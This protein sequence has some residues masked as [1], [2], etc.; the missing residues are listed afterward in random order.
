M[1]NAL[2]EDGMKKKASLNQSKRDILKAAAS[3]PLAASLAA[4]SG[5]SSST[6]SSSPNAQ[7]N[8]L[9]VLV[10]QMRFPN[11]FPSGISNADE[12]LK[13]F[14]P[15]TYALWKSGVKFSNHY[16]A[17]TACGPS[18]ATLVT[19][20]YTQQTW[21]V[22]TYAP[23]LGNTPPE[24]SPDMPTYGKL[25]QA[26]GYDTP[27]MGKWHL[28]EP[29]KTGMSRYGF[30]G[31]T[32]KYI[33]DAANLQG[34]YSD[35]NFVDSNGVKTPYYN[36]EFI[37]DVAVSWLKAKKISDR[38]W[39]LTVGLQNPH[40]YQFFPSGT[41]FKT[42]TSLYS[43][44]VANPTRSIQSS[45]YSAQPSATGVDWSTNVFNNIDVQSYG[46]PV[47][48]P[49]WESLDS[50]YQNKPK[51]QTLCRQWNAMQFGSAGETAS[52]TNYD[53]KV[54]P[55]TARY[56]YS[57][58]SPVIPGAPVPLTLG[59]SV[60]P[61]GYWQR[62]MAVY[63]L[64]MEIVDKSIG[65]VLSAM[66]A[67]VA[68][69][70]VIVFTSDHGEQAGSH[71]FISNKSSN[72]YDETIRVPLIVSDPTGKFTGD[73]DTQRTQITSAVDLAPMM[74]SFAYGGTRSWLT[75]DNATLYS[76]RF[77][78]FPLLKSAAA[79]GRDYALF[80]TD[81]TVSLW[82][83]FVT[84]PNS[85]K[86]QT[87]AHILGLIKQNDK[88]GLCSNWTPGTVNIVNDGRQ[89]GEYY[90]RSTPTG[91]LE[92]DNQ[93]STPGSAV[94]VAAMKNQLLNDL[95]PN[96]MRAALPASLKTPQDQS[97]QQIID[98]YLSQQS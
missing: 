48:P 20:L 30:E 9:F 72:V 94:K 81:E 80:S 45:T 47:L 35:P 66:P 25:F 32:E 58:Y 68:K 96:E 83:D 43:S 5:G 70:T 82:Q 21:N 67:D 52:V 1:I 62:G 24:L 90:D 4:C 38:P 91:R 69:N 93:Y 33:L 27:Y 40:D 78:M 15:N 65:K 19:G 63:T 56:A 2:G 75:G 3:V 53:I 7:P 46:Y 11:H 39:C 23:I 44:V 17:A 18:R 42:F 57:G 88:L 28:S 59:V 26:A 61:Y 12:F 77:D 37:A 86:N 85:A 98:Y 71:G 87:P 31:I 79:A 92:L 41:E 76:K 29:W 89:D 50:L 55:G 95:V 49:N 54:Y 10:D 64:A 6:V 22:A 8:V 51:A 73:I 97:K 13:R 34:T 14:M 84:A 74:V 36:D 16:I 60:A